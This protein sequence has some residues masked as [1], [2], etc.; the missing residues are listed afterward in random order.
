MCGQIGGLPRYELAAS[1]RCTA[2]QALQ[3]LLAWMVRRQPIRE[4]G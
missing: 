1:S 2:E 4:V 3:A